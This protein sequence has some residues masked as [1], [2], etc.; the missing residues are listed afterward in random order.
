MSNNNPC[1]KLVVVLG[2]HRSGTSAITRALTT[3]GVE[4]GDTLLMPMQGVNEKGFFEDIDF[5]SLNEELLRVCGR[6]WFS[7]EPI[8]QSEV[9]LLCNRGYLQKAI[10][11]LREKVS[12]HQFFGLKDPRTAKLLPFWSRVFSLCDLHIQYILV[13]RHPSH[14]Q[15]SFTLAVHRSLCS[16]LN[17][18]TIF[19]RLPTFCY[20]QKI[21]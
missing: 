20:V 16:V 12:K 2:A 4:L 21:N 7:L 19:S 8:Q 1:K 10:Q 11:L 15:L 14:S 3:M 17:S 13:F 9:D 5:M 18:F 6:T